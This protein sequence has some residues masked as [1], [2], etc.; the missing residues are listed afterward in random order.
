MV[1]GLRIAR[2]KEGSA[3]PPRKTDVFVNTS[4]PMRSPRG[5]CCIR[6][7]R[8]TS[9]IMEDH[10]ASFSAGKKIL[11][12][13]PVS[14]WWTSPVRPKN[15]TERSRRDLVVFRSALRIS[16]ALA[17]TARAL[18]DCRGGEGA[19]IV[20]IAQERYT[21]NP[22]NEDGQRSRKTVIVDGCRRRSE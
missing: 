8:I 5:L 13:M 11:S 21:E 4:S 2:V 6:P 22:V 7:L 3:E 16:V 17:K 18:G 15:S 14:T 1:A 20:V 9:S 19:E 12:R 10:L